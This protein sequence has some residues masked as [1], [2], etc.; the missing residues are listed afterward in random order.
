MGL[1]DGLPPV[2]IEIADPRLKVPGADHDELLIAD[3]DRWLTRNSRARPE[4]SRRDLVTSS[5]GR[6]RDEGR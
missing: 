6:M 5:A 4:E 3:V 1:R 2:T